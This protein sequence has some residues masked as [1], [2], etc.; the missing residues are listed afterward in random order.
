M[1]LVT[2]RG[3]TNDNVNKCGRERQVVRR[4]MHSGAWHR[5]I[6]DLSLPGPNSTHSHTN[7]YIM[8]GVNTGW[9]HIG[10]G[11]DRLAAYRGRRRQA[12]SI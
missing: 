11:G 9:Q 4:A 7:S 5:I 1:L 6:N 10:G 3:T 12:G 8:E 2:L